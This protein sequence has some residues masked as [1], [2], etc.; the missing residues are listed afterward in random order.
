MTAPIQRVIVNAQK[1]MTS[2]ANKHTPFVTDEWYVMGFT[3]DFDHS[4]KPMRLL[5]QGVVTYRKS[6]GHVVV[7][8]DRCPHRSFPLSRG[9][10]DGDVIVCGYHG[11]RFDGCGDLIEVPS[12]STCPKGVGIRNYATHEVHGL[13]WVWMG[14]VSEADVSKI[15]TQDWITDP[16]WACTSGY[17]HHPG[18][19]VSLHENLMDLTHLSFLHAA[20]IGTPD[21]AKAPYETELKEHTFKLVRR[22]VPTTLAPVWGKTTGL[23]GND[24][25]ARIATSEFLSPGL[26]RVSVTFY[27]SSL[28]ESERQYFQIKT[29]HILTPETNGTCHYFIVHGRNFAL[30]DKEL[31]HFMHEGLFAAFQE[32]VDG[33][34]A[35]EEKLT[36]YGDNLYE[37]S[38]ASDTPGV[39][40]RRYLKKRAVAC[41]PALAVDVKSMDHA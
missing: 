26:H 11:F 12:Q 18:N 3:A 37:I 1:S 34:S 7:L 2:L 35:L 19:Y 29:A 9:S 27:D 25:A 21:Y 41:V 30:D 33:L 28:P 4:L 5:G 36:E 31:E 39:A 22:V 16:E 10:L 8:E 24:Q 14:E 17:F 15:P 38:V 13:V 20:T 23:E 40:M 32:D 6:D